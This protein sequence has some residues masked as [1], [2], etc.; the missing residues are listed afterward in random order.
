M[1]KLIVDMFV[2]LDGV[3]QGPGGP[4]EDREGGFEHGGWQA[5]LSDEDSGRAIGEYVDRLDALLL[6]RKTYEIFAGYWPHAGD[7]PIAT[8]LNSVPKYVASTTLDSL[9]WNNS[10]LIEGDVPESIVHIK[11]QHKEVHVI[12]SAGLVQTLLQH[13]LVDDF[14]LWIY[15]VLLGSGKRLFAGGTIPTTLRVV[16]STTFANGT[17]QVTYARA[18]KPTY[19]TMGA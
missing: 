12:G 1:G 15:P 8:K 9:E 3:I 10:T 6:G 16:H 19:G 7:F 2:T 4:D 5:P 18:G 13:D 17:I 14:N 11:D